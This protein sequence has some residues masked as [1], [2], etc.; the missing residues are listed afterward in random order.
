MRRPLTLTTSLSALALSACAA[1]ERPTLLS[2][3]LYHGFT[4]IDPSAETVTEDAWL[5]TDAGVIAA[6]GVGAP[7][8]GDF[9]AETD[10]A[11]LYALPGFIDVHGHLTAGPHAIQFVDGAPTVTLEPD[12]ETAEFHA[13][14]ALAFGVTTIRNPGAS[15]Q[16]SAAY[17]ARLA[18]GEW[19]G[20]TAYHA[21]AVIQ[22]PPFGGS[23]F[24]YPA[25]PEEWN[26]EAARQAELGM[27]YFKLYHGLSEDELA[28]GVAAARA[29]GME[30]IAH[31][32]HVSWIRAA[33]LGVTGFLHAL[34]T[35]PDLLEDEAR[36]D[37]LAVRGHDARFMYQWFERVDLDGPRMQAL[38]A[39][40][41]EVDATVDLT[42]QVNILMTGPDG[43][44]R[45]YPEDISPYLH[46]RT[47]N[48]L[49]EFTSLSLAGWTDEDTALATAALD[50][51]YAF[52]RRLHAEGVA[53][54]VGSDGPGGGPLFSLEL[55]LMEQAGFSR[56]Q[57][58]E[59][60]TAGG[61]RVMR[62]EDQTGRLAPG[63]EADIVFLSGN[64][65]ADMAEAR[66]VAL[67]MSDGVLHDAAAMRAAAEA[68]TTDSSPT[69]P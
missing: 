12:D 18:S 64:P 58:L 59:L 53:I 63:Y 31:L 54:G 24:A 44:A 55:G 41:R 38:Y 47:L 39:A 62:L 57:V 3:A 67:V 66:N 32:D 4:L 29:Y 15:P 65:L 33:E 61:A 6:R 56:W 69:H 7:P 10:L 45:L 23:A 14:M 17:D 52:A 42:L 30:V 5:V 25:T 50:Q 8:T 16:A 1:T 48:A 19:I 34:P 11:G 49:R 40:L 26:A 21:G 9:I 37:F 2:G 68:R 43:H 22:P 36:E 51:V 13:R 60:A 28:A 35:S 20:P 27:R 46:P